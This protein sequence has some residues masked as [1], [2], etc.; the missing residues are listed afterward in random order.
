MNKIVQRALV[1]AW[2]KQHKILREIRDLAEV[3]VSFAYGCIRTA[4]TMIDMIMVNKSRKLIKEEK[5]KE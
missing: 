1:G 5:S 2:E 4:E 3:N